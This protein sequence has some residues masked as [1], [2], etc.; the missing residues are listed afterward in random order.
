M[1][2]VHYIEQ[3]GEILGWYDRDIHKTIPTPNIAI[4]EEN[5]EKSVRA[6]AN[7]I[8]TE[9]GTL[10]CRDFQSETQKKENTVSKLNSLCDSKSKQAK[11]YIAGREVTDEQVKRYEE[12]YQIA[13]EYQG[14]GLYAD[15]LQLEA[16]LQGLS[17]DALANLIIQKGNTWHEAILAFNSR[18]EAFRIK[19]SKLIE[20]GEVDKANN[21]IEQ[22]RAF[23]ADTN[24]EE[25]KALFHE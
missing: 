13:K 22:A 5:W 18:I 1:K 2:Y 14:S 9:T 7:C 3:T 10:F 23:G 25:I 15:K 11:N 6:N 12:K 19:V 17:V 4:S 16:D 8:D 24:D 21:I 20:A